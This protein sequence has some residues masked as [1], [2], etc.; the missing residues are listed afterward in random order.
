MHAFEIMTRPVVSVHRKTPIRRAVA[1]LYGHDFSALPVVDD[2]QRVIGVFTEADAL[3]S[4]LD[5]GTAELTV[6]A[7]MTTPAEVA[8]PDTEVAE[9]ARRMLANRLRCIPIVA[10]GLLFGVVSRHDLLRPLVRRDEAIA[11]AVSNLLADYSGHPD[12]WRV[13]VHS[14]VVSVNGRFSDD[15]ERGMVAAL[16]RT[17]PGVVE[18]ELHFEPSPVNGDA[19]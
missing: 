10:G 16:V 15:A 6:D 12:R 4:E 9:L 18:T 5:T 7:M 11:S 3:A 19:R 14:G 13:D 8:T 2:E 1:L 17:V